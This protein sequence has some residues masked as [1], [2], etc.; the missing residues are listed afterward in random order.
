[1]RHNANTCWADIQW[2]TE[3]YRLVTLF[4]A[5]NPLLGNVEPQNLH[6]EVL[7]SEKFIPLDMSL[8]ASQRARVRASA[9][10]DIRLSCAINA[11]SLGPSCAVEG[12]PEFIYYALVDKET[13]RAP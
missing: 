11:T 6:W 5:A 12:I 10:F 13:E 8:N 9:V 4:R 3:A 1:M 2:S 7:W